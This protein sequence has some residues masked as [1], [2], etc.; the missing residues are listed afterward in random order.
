M[1]RGKFASH[2]VIATFPRTEAAH[3][4]LRALLDS[5]LDMHDVQ[6]L[7]RQTEEDE[8]SAGLSEETSDTSNSLVEGTV[9][10]SAIGGLAGGVAG[11]LAG[12][13]AFGIPGVGPAVGT[14]IWA[15]TF[16]G[17]AAGS[18]VGF[19]AGGFARMWEMRY[20]DALK[21]GKALVSVHLDD[22]DRLEEAAQLLRD[23]QAENID[24]LDAQGELVRTE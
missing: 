20:L 2:N 21:E 1:D 9:K 24:H 23:H 22:A 8:S 14:G 11:F 15:A 3:E 19:M 10:G 5:G 4:A 13:V 18:T 17:A 7:T 12:A 16:G 6:L